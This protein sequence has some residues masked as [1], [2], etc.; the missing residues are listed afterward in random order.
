MELHLL[1]MRALPLRPGA[2]T[3]PPSS[4]LLLL[5]LGTHNKRTTE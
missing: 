4:I 3:A 1:A 5:R 2:H